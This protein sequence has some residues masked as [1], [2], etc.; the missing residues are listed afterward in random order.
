M[1]TRH[2]IKSKVKV[3]LSSSLEEIKKTTSIGKKM[4]LASKT[5]TDLHQTYEDLGHLVYQ[6]IKSGE[7]EWNHRKAQD[8]VKHIDILEEELREIEEE[9]KKL[10]V[11]SGPED[12]SKE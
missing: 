12:I 4:L 6:Q 2:K 1:S 10:K 5:N 11:A 9:V 8:L 3:L 7:L